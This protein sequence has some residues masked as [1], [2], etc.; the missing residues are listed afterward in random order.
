M[1]RYVHNTRWVLAGLIAAI[2]CGA[3]HAEPVFTI[4]DFVEESWTLTYPSGFV[5]TVG[6]TSPWPSE[7][8]W[9][10]DTIDILFY[11]GDASSGDTEDYTFTVNVNQQFTQEFTM[12]ILAGPDEA[13][14]VQVHSAYIDTPQV[15]SA[16][17]PPERF[18][19]G[20]YNRLRIQGIG[21]EVGGGN[22]AGCGWNQWQLI[23][24]YAADV[25]YMAQMMQLAR[26]SN[27][28]RDCIEPSGMVRDSIPLA[29]SASPI[30][31]AS[32]D[33]AGFI[34][35]GLC[36]ADETGMMADAEGLA[37][38]VVS[39]YS[40]HTPGVTPTRSADGHWIHYMDVNTGAYASGWDDTYSSIGSALLVAGGFFAA[41]HWPDNALIR[42]YADE[43][44]ATTDFDS[45]MHES[46]DGRIHMGAYST[47]GPVPNTLSPWNEYMLVASLALREPGAV[48]APQMIHL[49]RDTSQLPKASYMQ[50][51]TIGQS[52]GVFA[53]AFWIQQ[54]HFFNPDVATSETWDDYYENHRRADLLYCLGE[55]GQ[56][57]KYGLTAGPYP[58]GYAADRIYN[59]H[60]VVGPE[61]VVAWGDMDTMMQF[62]DE[63]PPESDSR[64]RYGLT[65]KS[66]V[67][68]GWWPWDAPVVDHTFLMFG[69]METL[70]PDFFKA[71]VFGQ[72]DSDGDGLADDYDN[73][74][75]AWN[76]SQL[77]SDEDGTGDACDCGAGSVF[78]S[79]ADGD[80]DLVDFA[81]FQF[82]AEPDGSDRIGSVWLL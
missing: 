59:H 14:M 38:S 6:V 33:A 51:E 5:G 26:M 37:E 27:Y 22:P 75:N 48:R 80:V 31:P 60:N 9:Q 39:A 66:I 81:D 76:R 52:S 64:W 67:D 49:W 47:G 11:L 3:V 79:D 73:C 71:R 29:P 34:L 7:M 82:C 13:D 57:Y 61:A 23:R 53:P 40:G 1:I 4:T 54:Q 44:F 35:V 36:V 65:R 45:M 43:M 24:N 46:L 15:V 12:T 8:G 69:L 32:P 63:Y 58:D 56:S 20:Q 30:H 50:F 77:D 41:N 74:P 78:D 70:E 72:V 28:L 2:L 42:A 25:V 10:G 68:A 16:T 17:I 19:P 21:V 55:L 18:V 62:L